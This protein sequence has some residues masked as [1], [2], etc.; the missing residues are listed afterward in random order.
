M[1]D[2]IILDSIESIYK[3]IDEYRE[4]PEEIII[5]LIKLHCYLNKSPQ[6]TQQTRAIENAISKNIR[7]HVANIIK[8]GYDISN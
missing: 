4:C 5:I 2:S 7:I 3:T 6:T 8:F 1:F